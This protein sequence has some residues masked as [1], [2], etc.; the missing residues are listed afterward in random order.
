M[1]I[2]VVIPTFNRRQYISRAIRSVL[3]QS[4]SVHEII[5]VD[6][7]STDGTATR[8]AKKFP[9]VRIITQRNQGV[10]SA[11]NAGIRAAKGNWIAF[12]D[13]DDEWDKDKLAAQVDAVE[14]SPQYEICHT[15]E[16]WIRDGKRVNPM[17]KHAKPDGWIFEHCLPLCCVS[18]SAVLVTRTILEDAGLFD[19]SLP[20]CEDYDL[21]L[22]IFSRVPVL[23]VADKLLIKYGGH[24]DQL[25]RKYWG[26]DRFRVSALIS[27]LEKNDLNERYRQ[28]AL[29]KLR[30]KLSILIN[31]FGKRGNSKQ[32]NYYQDILN[33]WSSGG[34]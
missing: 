5:V 16:I 21:W 23:L 13:S 7:G 14:Q 18:P 32:V 24:D 6:D 11:R 12:L 22:K 28:L 9:D 25:S 19:E 10:S 34:C 8:I 31:G 20:A 17:R 33:H 1:D 30:E 26:M 29:E 2:S 15:D 27:L 3:N 4:Y